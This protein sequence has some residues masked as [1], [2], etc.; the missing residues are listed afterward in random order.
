MIYLTFANIQ[1]FAVN[2]ADEKQKI[3]LNVFKRQMS[4]TYNFDQIK[5]EFQHK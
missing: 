4:N 5:P 3:V 2:I 1:L